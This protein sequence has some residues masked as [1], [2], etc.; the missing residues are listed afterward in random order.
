MTADYASLT[1][2]NCTSCG[3]SEDKSAYWT[4]VPYFQDN[5]TG[6]YEAVDNVGGML[7]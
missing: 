6:E 2:G 4:P 5:S 1:G 3:V 7:A